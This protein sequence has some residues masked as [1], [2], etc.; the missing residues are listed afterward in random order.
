MVENLLI[1]DNNNNFLY[2]I[3]KIIIIGT[4]IQKY[5]EFIKTTH[6]Y[7]EHIQFIHLYVVKM[8][9]IEN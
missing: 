3:L 2:N 4:M 9:S 6:L 8:I 1:L 7:I 5:Y